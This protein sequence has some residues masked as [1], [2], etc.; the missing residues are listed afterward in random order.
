LAGFSYDFQT[1]DPSK[2][3]H[4]LARTLD[5]LTDS[6]GIHS[7]SAFL[8]RAFLWT[9]PAILR[10]P[11]GR[12]KALSKS[13]RMLGKITDQLWT[14]RKNAGQIDQDAGKSIM[15]LLLQ[16]EKGNS[17]LGKEEIA[18]EVCACFC[19]NIAMNNVN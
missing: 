9:F 18:A 8:V 6:S 2:E 7:F 11:S 5:G 14:E 12:Q 13:R 17:S 19:Q 4:P 3:E 1:L 15:E 16:A 10:I